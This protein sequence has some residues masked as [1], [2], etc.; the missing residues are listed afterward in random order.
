M[1]VPGARAEGGPFVSSVVTAFLIAAPALSSAFFSSLA[2]SGVTIVPVT[3]GMAGARCANATV[4]A[5]SARIPMSG[6]VRR[7]D[8]PDLR[9]L[10]SNRCIAR[11]SRVRRRLFVPLARARRTVQ[12]CGAFG[13]HLLHLGAA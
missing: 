5:E 9:H 2:V 8:M 7:L 4:A 1:V 13:V 10:L 11:A 6:M 12:P 3:P